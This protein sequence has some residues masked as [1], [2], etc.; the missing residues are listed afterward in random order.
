METLLLLYTLILIG[1]VVMLIHVKMS[2]R[3]KGG[4]P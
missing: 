4:Q 3:K 2:K 1:A